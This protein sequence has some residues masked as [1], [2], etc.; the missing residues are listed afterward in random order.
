MEKAAGK[1][2]ILYSSFCDWCYRKTRSQKRSINAVFSLDEEAHI[3]E[4]LIKMYNHGYGLSPSALKMK[5]NEI[6]KNRWIPFKDGILGGGWM[7]W[8]K[9]CLLELT[10]RATQAKTLCLENS[11]LYIKIWS[12]YIMST[13]I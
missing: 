2:H 1:N 13:I 8:F 12:G 11:N 5:I 7:K 6:A 9:L 3:I 10:L 4:F